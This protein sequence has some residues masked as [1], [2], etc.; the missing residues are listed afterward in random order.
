MKRRDIFKGLTLLPFAGGILGGVLPSE[1][2]S[3]EPHPPKRDFFKELGV[4]PIINAGVTMT[5]RKSVV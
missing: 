3:A 2:A 1:T 5:D 4:T